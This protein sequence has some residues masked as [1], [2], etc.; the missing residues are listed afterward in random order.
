MSADAAGAVRR[1][2]PA[3]ADTLVMLAAEF[4]DLDGHPFQEATVRR[5]L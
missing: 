5:A 1:A 2:D 3:D 4:Y